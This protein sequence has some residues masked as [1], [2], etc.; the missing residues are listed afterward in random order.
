MD[1]FKETEEDIEQ[2]SFQNIKDKL[3][4]NKKLKILDIAPESEAARE[5]KAL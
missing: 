4:L 5:T 2:D 3:I 1:Q